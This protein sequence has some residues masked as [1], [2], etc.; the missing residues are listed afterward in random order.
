MTVTAGRLAAEL[1]TTPTR[2]GRWLRAQRARG[3]PLLAGRR[4]G[5]PYAF[6][7]EDADLL[8]AEYR[9][10]AALGHVNDSVIRRRAEAVIRD[11][12]ADRLG[13]PLA[14]RTIKLA[15]GAPAQVDA[16]SPDG[17]VLA[18]IFARQGELKGGQQKNVAID[19][20]KLITIRCE[21]HDTRLVIAFADEE[22]SRYATGGGWVAQ[23]LRTWNVDVEI[24]DIPQD[25]RDEILAAQ[26]RQRMVNA[27]DAADDVAS[28]T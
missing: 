21:H 25:L 18:E 17:K 20:L 15:A 13:V 8:A 22:A 27:D 1:Q 24:I 12:L 9:A 7:R 19:T 6:S 2:L 23:A 5:V 4:P 11:R 14:A 16:A 10:N 26:Q 28:D 3:H